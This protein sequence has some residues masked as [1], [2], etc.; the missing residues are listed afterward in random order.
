ML[1]RRNEDTS[2]LLLLACTDLCGIH[3]I[4]AP[5][6]LFGNTAGYQ[7][8]LL[9]PRLLVAHFHPRKMFDLELRQQVTLVLLVGLLFLEH[10]YWNCCWAFLGELSQKL[11]LPS[12]NWVALS[13]QGQTG[14]R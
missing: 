1:F 2:A 5:P 8:T 14:Y 9:C 13:G 3:L 6:L 12:H 10:H 11:L 7:P 4:C